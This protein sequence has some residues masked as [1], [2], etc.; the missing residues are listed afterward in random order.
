VTRRT[1]VALAIVPAVLIGL[2]VTNQYH[3]LVRETSRVVAEGDAVV[4]QRTFG[5][6]FW[7]AV[8]YSNL[9]NGVGTLLLVRKL[10][11]SRQLFRGQTLAI[12]TGVT[13][14][15]AAATLFYNGL[16][17]VEPEV[18]FSVTGL[19]FAV[20]ISR[21]GLLD[22]VPVGRGRSSGRWTAASSSWTTRIGSW[23]PTRRR[24]GCSAGRTPTP[25]SEAGSPRPARRA[26][27][28]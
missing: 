16:S 14:P 1:L 26:P 7:L 21:Y 13:V 9:V 19:A 11:R 18:F 12:L 23:T 2:S 10:V 25:S 27:S 22:V 17:P 3:H 28:S 6:A 20:A 5:P 24:V 4:L 8:V 15:W